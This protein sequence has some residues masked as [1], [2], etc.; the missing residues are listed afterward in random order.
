MSPGPRDPSRG[1]SSE[2]S[3]HL[4][5]KEAIPPA[6]RDVLGAHNFQDE[7]QDTVLA[8]LVRSVEPLPPSVTPVSMQVS[9]L[10]PIFFKKDSA[11]N[12]LA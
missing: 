2:L 7:F 11:L 5:F 3:S 6:C 10:A 4:V 8:F 9:A 12:M 1:D